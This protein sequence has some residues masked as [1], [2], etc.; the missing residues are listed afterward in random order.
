MRICPRCNQRTSVWS[1]GFGS[2]LC[3]PC[4][5]ARAAEL[6]R[7]AEDW[8]RAN[9]DRARRHQVCKFLYAVAVCIGVICLQFPLFGTSRLGMAM[10]VAFVVL[11]VLSVPVLLIYGL[12]FE[13]S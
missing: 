5:E 6:A 4:R 8:A 13:E 3:K 2:G 10:A 9:P 12:F 1:A 11:V 7:R